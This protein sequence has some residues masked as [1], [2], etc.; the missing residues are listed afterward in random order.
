MR[1]AYEYE[2]ECRASAALRDHSI[3]LT[4]R[5]NQ[6]RAYTPLALLRLHTRVP[7]KSFEKK[8]LILSDTP[9]RIYYS[10]FGHLYHFKFFTLPY[11]ACLLCE[12]IQSMSFLF[13]NLAVIEE[14]LVL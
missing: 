9:Y 12:E 11:H 6:T 5:V 13:I 4:I 7:D 14:A 2:H 8:R 10:L 1:R 3:I